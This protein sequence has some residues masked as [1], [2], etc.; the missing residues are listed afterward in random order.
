MEMT[1][2]HPKDRDQTLL[3]FLDAQRDAVLSIV[4]GWTRQLPGEWTS[5]LGWR[6]HREATRSQGAAQTWRPRAGQWSVEDD[7]TCSVRAWSPHLYV[8]T[9][10]DLHQQRHGHELLLPY[11]YSEVL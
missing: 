11:K 4:G 10:S 5:G 3:A 2:N 1:G 8:F 6:S 9:L 7:S